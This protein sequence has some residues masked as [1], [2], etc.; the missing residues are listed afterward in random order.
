MMLQLYTDAHNDAIN[1]LAFHSSGRYLTTASS[2]STLKIFDLRKGTL[3]YSL[4]GHEGGVQAVN[5]AKTALYL[6]A[7]VL[8]EI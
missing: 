5:L 7:G 1:S 3:M 4:Y 6:Q 8:T 2:D